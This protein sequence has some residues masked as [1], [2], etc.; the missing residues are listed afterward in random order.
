MKYTL[1]LILAFAYVLTACAQNKTVKNITVENFQ[2]KM[3]QDSSI[4]ILDVRNPQELT[5]PL[6]SI[7]G[8]INIPVQELGSRINELEV[9]KDKEIAVIC[10]TGRRSLTATEI[11][12]NSGFDAM[13]ILGGMVEYRN[14]EKE[15]NSTKMENPTNQLK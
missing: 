10:R 5:G 2:E 13:N 4:V 15:I 3:L 12:D 8:A 14:F 11:L 6:G 1:Y 9:Y 7:K